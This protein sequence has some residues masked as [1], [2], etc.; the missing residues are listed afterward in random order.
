MVRRSGR[1]S[2]PPDPAWSPS[3]EAVV[4]EG[5]AAG[6]AYA[7]Q[8]DGSC[9]ARDYYE[10]LNPADQQK[11][12]HVFIVMTEHGKISNPEKFRRDVGQTTCLLAGRPVKIVIAEFKIHSRRVLAY[13]RGRW[14]L[15]LAGFDKGSDLRTEVAR[16]GVLACQHWGASL[17]SG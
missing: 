2:E 14:W 12:D 1:R 9:R 16:A 5:I 4:E 7:V 13:Q 6:L 3:A 8:T 17:R 10:G 11:I 15:L